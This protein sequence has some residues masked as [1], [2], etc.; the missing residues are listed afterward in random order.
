MMKKTFNLFFFLLLFCFSKAQIPQGYYDSAYG[1]NGLALKVAL[2]NII[3]NHTV[4]SYSN[5]DNEFPSTDN[6]GGNIV[7][8]IYSDVP[9]GTP[10]YTFSYA[11]SSDQCGNYSAEGDCYN[12]EHSWPQSWFNSTSIPTYSDLFHIYPTDG[13]VNNRRSNYPYGE[14]SNPT[15]SSQNGSKLGPCTFPG[16]TSTVFEPIDE[17]K[18]DIARSYFYITVR[19]YSESSSWPGSSMTT[20]S[21]LKDWAYNLMYQWHINDPVSQKETDRNNAIYAIQHNRNPFI[22]HPE[23]VDSILHPLGILNIT[24]I[25][26]N[27][28]VYPNPTDKEIVISNNNLMTDIVLFNALGQEVKTLHNVGIKQT[29]LDLSDLEQGYY[30]LQV[31]SEKSIYLQKII[32]Y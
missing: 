29:K 8:D 18:G 21:E 12:K 24:K 13:Y 7:W 16:Y 32:K 15:W 17:F 11:V 3:K 20:G 9:S 14:V 19:Y 23:W 30:L 4:I 27:I 6:M 10:P 26:N 2:H 25:Q 1:L 22:D 31:K 28:S 5:L